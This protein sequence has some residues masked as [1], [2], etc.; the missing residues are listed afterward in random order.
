MIIIKINNLE[1]IGALLELF[2]PLGLL[3]FELIRLQ[4]PSFSVQPYQ[5]NKQQSVNPTTNTRFFHR[6]L[7]QNK[8][9][10]VNPTTNTKFFCTTLSQNK[11]QQSVATVMITKGKGLLK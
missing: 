4:I 11:Q 10:S 3:I 6:T 1:L 9:L 8:Q 2:S 7:P 5:Q